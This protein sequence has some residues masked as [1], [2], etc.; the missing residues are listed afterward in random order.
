MR[1]KIPKVSV[2]RMELASKKID[3]QLFQ[4]TSN[5]SFFPRVLIIT[6]FLNFLRLGIADS[7]FDSRTGGHGFSSSSIQHFHEKP[8][9]II[10]ELAH[11]AQGKNEHKRVTFK[12]NTVFL[13]QLLKLLKL[14]VSGHRPKTQE[15]LG[16]IVLCLVLFHLS[17]IP[18]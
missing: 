7:T 12:C 15:L 16:V 4:D 8:L 2:K 10:R 9:N 18:H 3:P 5:K 1:T 17:Q 11:T 6:I 14:F 13:G